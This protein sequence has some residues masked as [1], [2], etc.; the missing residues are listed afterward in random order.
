MVDYSTCPKCGLVRGFEPEICDCGYDFL[1]VNKQQEI[2]GIVLGSIQRERR[3]RGL[4]TL[5]GVAELGKPA[6]SISYPLA[7]TDNPEIDVFLP[8][9]R[10]R[11]TEEGYR[12]LEVSMAFSRRVWPI[13]TC[14]NVIAE[15]ILETF[16]DA[17]DNVWEDFG[18][19]S[20]L[21]DR[22][23]TP[24]D[25]G[26][27]AVLGLGYTDGNA[28]VVSHID[29]E[30][31]KLGAAPLEID[32]SLRQISRAYLAMSGAIGT[33]QLNEDVMRYGYMKQGYRAR[34]YHGGTFV[35]VP[36]DW[37][38]RLYIP[39]VA[40]LCADELLRIDGER[41]TRS[42]WQHIG[43]AVQLGPVLPT[44]P[45]IE[46][47]RRVP[48]FTVEYIIGWRLLDSADRPTNF[49]SPPP[50]TPRKWWWPFG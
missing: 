24:G 1:A 11:V 19:G 7:E 4:P 10:Q 13:D 26:I 16:T 36:A 5:V 29:K 30:R 40:R 49:P 28:L 18:I 43:V 48:S 31:R 25:F 14:N 44:H 20:I 46:R 50:E 35:P 33:E 32:T 34:Y 38:E 41:L 27:C 42:D 37:D 39:D 22:A 17:L 12:G 6:M 8:D 21:N 23:V 3:M 9:Y 15:D 2:M 45:K 47:E